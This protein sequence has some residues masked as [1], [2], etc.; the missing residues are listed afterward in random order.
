MNA[1]TAPK[2]TN[3][4][5]EG[6]EYALYREK[7]LSAREMAKTSLVDVESDPGLVV[8]SKQ[9][10]ILNSEF[11]AKDADFSFERIVTPVITLC[12]FPE[13]DFSI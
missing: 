7:P 12:F 10:E 5:V 3:K 2:T 9:Q 6:V 1:I 11:E 8:S 13:S 4:D